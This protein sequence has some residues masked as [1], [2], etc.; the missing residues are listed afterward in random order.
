LDFDGYVNFFMVTL[1]VIQYK[2]N[3][4]QIGCMRIITLVVHFSDTL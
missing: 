1:S 2:T 4:G 3:V